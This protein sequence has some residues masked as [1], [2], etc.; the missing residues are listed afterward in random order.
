MTK[1]PDTPIDLETKFQL[2]AEKWDEE[3][4]F[5]SD[6]TKIAAHPAYQEVIRMGMPVVP[7]LLRE[8]EKD[9]SHWFEALRAITGENPVPPE[10]RG[11]IPAM[12]QDWLAWGKGRGL[13]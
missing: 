9:H 5:L 13:I 6:S 8:M 12:V 3:T 7:L 11:R 10:H 4:C 1:L 2:L